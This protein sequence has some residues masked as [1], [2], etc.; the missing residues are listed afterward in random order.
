MRYTN[1][2][3]FHGNYPTFATKNEAML[4]MLKGLYWNP[5]DLAAVFKTKDGK[6]FYALH[7]DEIGN[8][9]EEYAENGKTYYCAHDDDALMDRLYAKELR[10]EFDKV[11][12]CDHPQYRALWRHHFGDLADCA[13]GLGGYTA[14]AG[15]MEGHVDWVANFKRIWTEEVTKVA[16]ELYRG[17]ARAN[18]IAAWTR[19]NTLHELAGITEK[20][21]VKLQILDEHEYREF[22]RQWAR[23]TAQMADLRASER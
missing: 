1:V 8:L 21:W 15:M 13:D 5:C 10:K 11:V 6:Y 18:A 23:D 4:E 16:K 12:P 17:K 3:K 2:P 22:A 9:I 19:G 14:P 20:Q 7:E